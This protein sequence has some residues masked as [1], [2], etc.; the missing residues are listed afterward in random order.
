MCQIERHGL[1]R[2]RFRRN[3]HSRKSARSG[4]QNNGR[5]STVAAGKVITLWVTLKSI[6][7]AVT[8]FASES[9]LRAG[10]EPAPSL[11]TR[12]PLDDEGRPSRRLRRRVGGPGPAHR[13]TPDLRVAARVL[14]IPRLPPFPGL[15]CAR[16]LWPNVQEHLHQSPARDRFP[17]RHPPTSFFPMCVRMGG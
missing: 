17:A 10:S 7:F 16:R 11:R 12:G 9:G 6:L 2:C 1:P 5:D 14:F 8:A 15:L 13:A 3:Y 4:S